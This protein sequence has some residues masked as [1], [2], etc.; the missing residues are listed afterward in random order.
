MREVIHLTAH[1]N[2]VQ[3]SLNKKKVQLDIEGV[4]MYR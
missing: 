2:I 3:D 1:L 4:Q